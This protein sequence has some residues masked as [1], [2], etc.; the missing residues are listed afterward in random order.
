MISFVSPAKKSGAFIGVLGTD[1]LLDD[2][3]ASVLGIKL[4]GEGY[5]MLLSKDGQVLVHRDGARVTKPAADLA[6]ELKPE[7]LMVLAKS[8]EMREVKLDNTD[9][10]L[11]VH[12]ID[13]ADLYLALA[14]RQER[15]SGAAQFAAV[16]GADYPGGDP[17]GGRSAHPGCWSAACCAA[18]ATSTT[19]WSRL[20][21]AAAT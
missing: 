13:G 9:K 6:P 4:V 17:A 19:R 14:C 15:R 10:Y 16:A 3:V 8:N 11:F 7:Q 2:I 12:A 18:S 21:T 5:T 20:P 1:V